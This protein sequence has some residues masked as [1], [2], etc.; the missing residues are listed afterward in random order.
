[1]TIVVMVI[2]WF[3]KERARGNTTNAFLVLVLKANVLKF[4]ISK[5]NNFPQNK[6]IIGAIIIKQI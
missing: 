1:M 2:Q 3:G 4:G 5:R 6:P